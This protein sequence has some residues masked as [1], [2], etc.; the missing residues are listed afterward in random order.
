MPAFKTIISN[1]NSPRLEAVGILLYETTYIF[2]PGFG[3]WP[4]LPLCLI[5]LFMVTPIRI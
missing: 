5:V 1:K 4:V 3:L 2:L